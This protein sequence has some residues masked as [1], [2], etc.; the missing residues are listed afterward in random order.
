MVKVKVK[1]SLLVKLILWSNLKFQSFQLVLIIESSHWVSNLVLSRWY[2]VSDWK[3]SWTMLQDF[4][5]L[6]L[7]MLCK[8]YHLAKHECVCREII[9]YLVQ[10]VI[11][12]S[13][14]SEEQAHPPQQLRLQ[15]PSL[16]KLLSF[17]FVY[18]KGDSC[19]ITN[20]ERSV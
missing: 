9:R 2:L 20:C 1:G 12:D 4:K 16:I 7:Y 3:T 10:D 17:K 6:H 19:Y 18:I 14:H 15:V 5:G 13:M 8:L 11:L